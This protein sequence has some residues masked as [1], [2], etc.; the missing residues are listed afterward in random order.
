MRKLN[1]LIL[2]WK[3]G[4]VVDL[5]APHDVLTQRVDDKLPKQPDLARMMRESYELLKDHPIN[6]KRKEKGINPAN[7]IWF[8]AT[9]CFCCSKSYSRR[10]TCIC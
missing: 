9:S 5:V 10:R 1:S 3:K 8:W 2:I 4:E 6:I 7:S